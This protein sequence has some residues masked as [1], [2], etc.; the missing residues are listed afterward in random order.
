[1]NRAPFVYSQVRRH[2]AFEEAKTDPWRA[3]PS[4]T[5]LEEARAFARRLITQARH[6]AD[7]T[8]LLD[9][10]RPMGRTLAGKALR[11]VMMIAWMA[12]VCAVTRDVALRVARWQNGRVAT[13]AP[14]TN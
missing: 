5:E 12:L 9:E 8:R 13:A 3:P 1:M 11:G 6:D 7:E 14:F 2:N 4:S 10:R